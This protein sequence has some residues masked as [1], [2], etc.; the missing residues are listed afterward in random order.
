MN[1]H[2]G[3]HAQ[4]TWCDRQRYADQSER[5]IFEAAARNQNRP[6]TPSEPRSTEP[7]DIGYLVATVIEG[8]Q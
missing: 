2:M 4:C 3:Q 5:L 7:V 6:H 1:P 8:P